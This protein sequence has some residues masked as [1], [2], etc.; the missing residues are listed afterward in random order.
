MH[1]GRE[2]IFWGTVPK[3]WLTCWRSA[4]QKWKNLSVQSKVL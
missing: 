4:R 1:A 2:V 3:S